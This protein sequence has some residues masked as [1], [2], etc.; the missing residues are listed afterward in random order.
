MFD[1]KLPVKLSYH[2]VIV[3]QDHLYVIGGYSTSEKKTSDAIYELTLSPPYTTKLLTRMPQPRL[4]HGAEVVNGRLFILGG[5]TTGF[6][7]DAIDSVVVYDFATNECNQCPSLPK[8]VCKMSTVSWGN[9]V[10]VVGGADKNSQDLEDVVMYHTGTGRS[11]RL[12]SL[13]HKRCD[14]S[15][16]IMH[17]VIVVLGGRSDQQGYLN[18]VESFTMG[19]EQWKELP[20]MREKKFCNCCG[21]T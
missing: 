19:D 2:V 15:A 7:K 5:S 17:D 4:S 9:V 3:H 10:I 13:I 12:P 21:E 14:S 6:S 20:G 11:E 18:S 1:G 16:V 8:S